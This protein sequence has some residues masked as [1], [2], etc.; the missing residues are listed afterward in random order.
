VVYAIKVKSM[1]K[2]YPEAGQRVRKWVSRKQAAKL[3]DEPELARILKD[4]D[5]RQA[6]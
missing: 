5:P 4:F 1:S 3:V 2:A 6:A